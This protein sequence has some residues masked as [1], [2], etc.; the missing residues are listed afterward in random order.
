MTKKIIF[1]FFL[2]NI[3]EL[4]NISYLSESEYNIY[5]YFQLKG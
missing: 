3:L 4:W 2:L 1:S 5:V